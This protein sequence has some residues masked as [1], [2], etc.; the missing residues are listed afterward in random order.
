MANQKI[1]PGFSIQAD[2]S[3]LEFQYGDSTFGPQTEKRRLDANRQSLSDPDVDGPDIVYAV[4]MWAKK[5][6]EKI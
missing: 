4:E 6:I 2:L 3:N 5:K 1:D